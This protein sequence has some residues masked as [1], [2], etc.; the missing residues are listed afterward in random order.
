VPGSGRRAA[1]VGNLTTWG[2]SEVERL[3]RPGTAATHD[4]QTRL[5]GV[6]LYA[7]I[8]GATWWLLPQTLP[9]V[10]PSAGFGMA[11]HAGMRRP[12][13]GLAGFGLLLV[14]VPLL[15]F[16]SLLVDAFAG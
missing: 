8:V 5:V 10:A 7:T 1:S 3:A 12:W 13:L 2:G 9:F 6:V 4:R 11:L 16:P 14:V 15:F